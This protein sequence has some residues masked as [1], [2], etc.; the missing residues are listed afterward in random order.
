MQERRPSGCMCALQLCC[1]ATYFWRCNSLI[2]ACL[3]FS[4][5]RCATSKALQTVS[6]CHTHC[7]HQHF[8]W[9]SFPCFTLMQSIVI[10]SL[11]SNIHPIEEV[12]KIQHKLLEFNH[13]MFVAMQCISIHQVQFCKKPIRTQQHVT[14]RKLQ[15]FQSVGHALSIHQNEVVLLHVSQT[16]PRYLLLWPQL[17]YN[18]RIKLAN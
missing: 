15:L 11:L 8:N 13:S 16:S 9:T 5:K 18:L 10:H 17:F 4:T 1:A 12:C 3:I 14:S 6:Q 7:R 2:C